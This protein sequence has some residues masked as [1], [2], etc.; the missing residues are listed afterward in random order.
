[1]ALFVKMEGVPDWIRIGWGYQQRVI[2][3]A[4][5][6]AWH[7]HIATIRSIASRR[8]TAYWLRLEG[9]DLMARYEASQLRPVSAVDQLGALADE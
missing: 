8:P 7:D 9:R 1:M 4:P 2:I 6:T 5:G 3:N